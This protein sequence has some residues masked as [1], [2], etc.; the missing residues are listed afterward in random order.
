M[1]RESQTYLW[2]D[3]VAPER[4]AEIGGLE[5]VKV[6]PHRNSI[7]ADL[8]DRLLDTA[9]DHIDVLVLAGLF[10]VERPTFAKDI[11]SKAA[12]GAK[13]RLLFGDP[14]SREAAKRSEEEQLG[15]GTVAAR[16]PQRSC[17]GPSPRRRR[18]RQH[19]VAQDHALQLGVPFR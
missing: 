5:V 6:Y 10:L 13:I 12:A 19:S 18:Q 15:K 9:T 3:A 7:P 14:G 17:A 4:A 8:W 11:T 16:Y 1:V 2:P